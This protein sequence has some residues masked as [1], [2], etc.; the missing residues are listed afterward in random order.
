MNNDEG[1]N[2]HDTYEYDDDCYD[3]DDDT[4]RFP[5]LTR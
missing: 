1:D 2:D 5:D 4:Q 3:D